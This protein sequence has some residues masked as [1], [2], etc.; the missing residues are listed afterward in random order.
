MKLSSRKELLK[1]SELTLKSIKKSLNESAVSQ[2][3]FE[4]A[5][6]WISDAIRLGMTNKNK[7]RY[8]LLLKKISNYNQIP[9]VSPDDAKKYAKDISLNSLIILSLFKDVKE[10]ITKEEKN[11][12]KAQNRLVKLKKMRDELPE[13]QKI[14]GS[15]QS[16][17][18]KM[19]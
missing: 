12:E 8:T 7:D 5:V 1:E 2:S 13:I 11:F 16:D 18:D 6:K 14:I 19:I 4:S 10:N 3:E 17:V 9:N 15:I